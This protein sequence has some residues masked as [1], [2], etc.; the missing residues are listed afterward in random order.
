MVVD[1]R[2]YG[3]GAGDLLALAVDA[4][5][6]IAPMRAALGIVDG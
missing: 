4:G 5:D 6:D 3:V 2:E 1:L